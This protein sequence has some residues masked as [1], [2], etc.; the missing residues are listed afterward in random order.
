MEQVEN[1]H[2]AQSSMSPANALLSRS[3]AAPETKPTVP[4]IV[5]RNAA[6]KS[7][8]RTMAILEY[9]D[10]IQ[11]EARASELTKN[12]GLPQ[13]SLSYLLNSLVQMGYLEK[14]PQTKT[15]R[16]TTRV[17]LLGSWIS[18]RE[19]SDGR[20]I[21]LLESVHKRTSLTVTLAARN[22]IYARYI[23]VME[24][25][26]RFPSHIPVGTCRLLVWSA[27]GIALLANEDKR[28]IR[29]LVERSNAEHP[30][31]KKRIDYNVVWDNLES[32][33]ARGYFISN[34]FV[35]PGAA[36]LAIRLPANAGDG[37][38]LCIG[39]SAR[40]CD[41]VEGEA[42]FVSILREEIHSAYG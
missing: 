20:L 5:S 26:S 33:R 36:H 38:P 11:R 40:N 35:T 42:D 13:S 17:A 1:V 24:Q 16:P 15:F 30:E 29:L 27:S 37:R 34:S 22:G 21:R 28:L 10:D 7:A 31:N 41:L 3:E 32:Y 8:V 25:A 39:L 19:V 2:A 9:F 14:N 23:Q 18:R 4:L 6:I 12:L